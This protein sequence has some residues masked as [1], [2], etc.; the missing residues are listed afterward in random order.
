MASIW[1]KLQGRDSRESNAIA[2]VQDK[3][4]QDDTDRADANHVRSADTVHEDAPT[5]PVENKATGEREEPLEFDPTAGY[6]T[7]I[8]L[9][10][11]VLGITLAVLCVALV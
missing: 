5:Q 8:P 6:I 10:L 9:Y 3:H 7:G 11:I 1:K 4:E 2:I